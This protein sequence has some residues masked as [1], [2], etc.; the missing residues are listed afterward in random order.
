MKLA[1]KKFQG[2][3]WID[4]ESCLNAFLVLRMPVAISSL[5]ISDPDQNWTEPPLSDLDVKLL[6]VGSNF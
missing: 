6:L 1:S 2:N 5:F 3:W 4:E